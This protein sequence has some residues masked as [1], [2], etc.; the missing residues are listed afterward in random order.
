MRLQQ[1]HSH[2]A[3]RLAA[4]ARSNAY[5]ASRAVGSH[6]HDV[7]HFLAVP[8]EKRRGCQER[9]ANPG[10]A[11]VAQLQGGHISEAHRN[12]PEDGRERS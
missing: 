2:H 5:I 7:A 8:D 9:C 1:W 12:A 6:E 10:H 11:P 3:S 4:N